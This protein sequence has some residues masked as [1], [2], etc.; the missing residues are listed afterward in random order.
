MKLDLLTVSRTFHKFCLGFF[1]IFSVLAA[2]GAF[3]GG[4][5]GHTLS[6]RA[7][8]LVFSSDSGYPIIRDSGV[9]IVRIGGHTFDETTR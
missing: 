3:S 1:A 4:Y 9:T 2:W 5:C 8:L 7:K 6:H